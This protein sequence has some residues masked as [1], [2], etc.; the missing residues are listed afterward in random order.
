MIG[1]VSLGL[2]PSRA[3]AQGTAKYRL[4][5]NLTWSR[6]THP[7]EFPAGAHFSDLIGATHDARYTMFTDGHTASSGL[8]LLAENGRTAILR[9]ELVE[10]T[11]RNRVKTVFTAEGLY[12]LPGM[13][14]AEFE[15]EPQHRLV[16]FT[17]MIAPSP[18]WFTGLA[19]VDLAPSGT[20]LDRIERPLWAWDAGTDSGATFDAPDADQQPRSCIRLIASPHFLSDSGL[21]RVGIARLERLG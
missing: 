9:E 17:T 1:A 15:I 18:D 4:Q 11:R 8:K 3:W 20:W 2:V 7:H 12:T 21:L 14:K 5:L 16:S 13:I 19:G 6:E 10:A